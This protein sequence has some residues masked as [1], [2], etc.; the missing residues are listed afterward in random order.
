MENGFHKL[1]QSLFSKLEKR[2]PQIRRQRLVLAQRV[3]H[4]QALQ[5]M[6]VVI[7]IAN[8]ELAREFL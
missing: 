4:Q 8:E 3:A 1:R 5:C 6:R 2:N 7:R